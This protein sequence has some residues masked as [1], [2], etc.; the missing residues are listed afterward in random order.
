MSKVLV[1]SVSKALLAGVL[2][3]IHFGAA[4]SNGEKTAATQPSGKSSAETRRLLKRETGTD[5]IV[6]IRRR[7]LNPNHYYTEHINSE[8]KPGGSVC[9]LDLNDGSVREI[10]MKKPGV[11]NRFDISYDAI[12]IVFDF[13]D[14]H[15]EGYRIYEAD[16]KTGKVRQLTHPPAN[17]DKLQERYKVRTLW[18]SNWDKYHH[19][20]SLVKE[21]KDRSARKRLIGLHIDELGTD[22]KYREAHTLFGNQ[23]V[24]LK[25][26][27]LKIWNLRPDQ[28]KRAAKLAASCSP[29]LSVSEKA[30]VARWVDT[31]CQYYGSYWG[32]RNVKYK[33]HPNYRTRVTFDQ[34]LAPR[35]P[36]PEDKR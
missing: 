31:N 18:D 13:K 16:I 11:I 32:R 25:M 36:T 9:I 27:G 34:V 3:A 14:D 19:G 10:R 29:K 22:A 4:V 28:K 1:T 30:K 21:P 26:L 7:T 8:F 33:K 6:F 17:E 12:R 35:S 15:M 20:K 23:S 24:L 2:L 5:K